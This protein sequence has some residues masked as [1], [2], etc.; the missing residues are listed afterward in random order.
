M[1]NEVIDKYG[2]EISANTE[3][4]N[5]SIDAAVAKTKEFEVQQKRLIKQIDE[6]AE[7]QE[8]AAKSVENNRKS[9]EKVKSA[10][11]AATKEFGKESEEVKKLVERKE[12]LE[13]TSE[14]LKKRVENLKKSETSLLSKLSSVNKA[15]EGQSASLDETGQSAKQAGQ[16]LDGISSKMS[17]LSKIIAGLVTA[18][19]GKSFLKATI[20]SLAEFEQYETSFAVM[21][22][23]MGKAKKMIEDLQNFASKTP[24][25]MTDIVPSAQLLMNYG[26]AAEDVIET[27]TRLGDLSQGQ[28]DKLDRVALA[29]GQMLAKGKVTNEELLQLTEAGA[30]VMQQLADNL[31]VSSGELQDMVSKGMVGIDDLNAAIESL[32]TG[33]GKF[34]GM[35]KAQSETLVGQWSTLKDTFSQIA[36]DIGEESFD[37]LKKSL[38]DVSDELER[39]QESGELEQMA[40]RWGVVFGKI[41]ELVTKTTTYL[42]K[43]KEAVGALV[44]AYGALKVIQQV[45]AM[46]TAYQTA[47]KTATTAQAAFNTVAAANPYM[48]LASGLALVIGSVIMFTDEA[49]AAT[50]ELEELNEK[51]QS[52]NSDQIDLASDRIAELSLAEKAVSDIQTLYEQFVQTGNGADE[53]SAAVD[54]LNGILGYEAATFDLSTGSLDMNTQAIYNNIEAMKARALQ[55]AAE[56]E[57]VSAAKQKMKAEQQVE[58]LNEQLKKAEEQRENAKKVKAPFSP[59]FTGSLFNFGVKSGIDIQMSK[60]VSDLNKQ[61]ESQQEIAEKAGKYMDDLTGKISEYAKESEKASTEVKDSWEKEASAKAPPVSGDA[62]KKT[63]TAAR[64]QAKESAKAW[65]DE[66][67]SELQYLRNMDEISEQEYINGLVEIR[68][69]YRENDLEKYR[70][71]NLEIYRLQQNALKEIEQKQKE[72][73]RIVKN[74]FDKQLQIA[75]EYLNQRK[76]QISEEYDAAVKAVNARYDAQAEAS[77]AGYEAEKKRVDGIIDQINREIEARRSARDQEKF[78]DELSLSERKVQ[79]LQTKISFARTPEEKAELE[80]ELKRQQ[81]ELKDLNV[82]K[83]IRELESQKK[84]HEERLSQLEEQ[85]KAESEYIEQKRK[86]ELSALEEARNKTLQNLDDTFKT[87]ESNLHKTYGYVNNETIAIGQRFANAT[88]DAIDA[89]FQTVASNAQSV[90]D[91]MIASVHSAISQMESAIAST[92]ERAQTAASGIRGTTYSS[93][94]NRSAKIVNNNYNGMTANQVNS[95]MNRQIDRMLYGRR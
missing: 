38:S 25:E 65:Q 75:K 32:T 88:V 7:K 69:S 10:I 93:S 63:A 57:L 80:K 35:M 4:Y 55:I 83:E 8:K 28:A 15:L 18:Q 78:E 40:E 70:K 73:E 42:V 43:H 68:D 95:I 77:R 72:N 44:V 6:N 2:V 31:K 39:M 60:K 71:Y 66:Y 29:Y 23:D 94:D 49:S 82:E 89:G 87:F 9:M 51:M 91:S 3:K 34:A 19:A 46:M 17:G 20:G 85:Y 11:K 37:T 26:V 5:Q 53:L 22:G 21:L 59:S 67:Y 1:A 74:S 14:N 92:E 36:R 45:S 56:D 64:K 52:L 79:S 81:E 62:Q 33:T 50:A 61:L 47:I 27:L 16:S 30:P 41:T 58:R 13:K 12:K 76:Q 48:L 84:E 90:I 86:E 54:N 24:F